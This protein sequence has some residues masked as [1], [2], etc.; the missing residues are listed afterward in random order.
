[1]SLAF[2][3]LAIFA[4]ALPGIILRNSYRNGFF[5][6]RPRQT[7]PVAEEVAYSL[8]LACALHALF[9]SVVHHWFWPIDFD[10]V[11]ILLL[12]QYGKDSNLLLPSVQALTCHP[13]R[14]FTY[15]AGL[16]AFSATLG[17]GAHALV[18]RL[19]LDRRLPFLR[20][21]HQWHYLL[22]GEI[23]R[24]PE[25]KSSVPEVFDLIS[26]GC[27]VD[28]NAGSFLY[29]GVLDSFYFNKAGDLDLL[30]LTGSARRSIDPEKEGPEGRKPDYFFIDAE[31][32]Y[33]KYSEIRN[34]SIKYVVLPIETSERNERPESPVPSPE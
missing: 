3:A 26:V 33:L 10:A 8:V 31:Y 5:W 15:F 19:R 18:R 23:A 13:G 6:D 2:Q 34:V 29:V 20:F 7:L 21:D 4:L 27:V 24:F 1:V 32:L 12:G 22:R 9:A 14:I 17:F 25:T 28:T 16:Y 30:V 11:G